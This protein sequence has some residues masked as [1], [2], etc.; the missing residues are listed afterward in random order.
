MPLS[1]FL[2]GFW[3]TWN[4]GCRF[5]HGETR[6]ARTEWRPLGER[7]SVSGSAE[8]RHSRS[9]GSRRAPFRTDSIKNAGRDAG[10]EVTDKVPST[11][12]LTG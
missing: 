10:A 2:N 7:A 11:S 12:L 5:T 9:G 8:V 1:C 6:K 3:E 4:S